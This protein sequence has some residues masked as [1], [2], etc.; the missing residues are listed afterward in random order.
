VALAK[1]VDLEPHAADLPS[2]RTAREVLIAVIREPA[3]VIG[4]TVII[5]VVLVAVLAPLL[6]PYSPTATDP[7]HIL[8][9]PGHGH[10]LGTDDAGRD[11]LSRVIF[12]TRPALLV[13]ALAVLVGGTLGI[14]LGVLAGYTRGIVESVIMRIC[15]VAFAFPLVLIGICAVVVLGPST[16]TVGLAVGIGVAPMFIRLARAEVLEET[17]LDHIHAA[18]GMGGTSWW[19]IRRHVIPNIMTTMIVQLASTMSVAVV[20]ASALDFLGLGAQVPAPS[21]GNMLQ[22]SRQ[23]LSQAP[24]FA[25]TPGVVLTVFVLA[26]NLFAAA[27]TNALD[28]RQRTRLLRTRGFVGRARY[29]GLTSAGQAEVLK[30]Q[31]TAMREGA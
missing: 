1:N 17:S 22:E 23:Y 26:V 21:W 29:R 10:L 18:R 13:A 5:A 11:V 28:P 6:A 20:I 4:G 25:I 19:I 2:P 16:S 9:G 14:G 15:D 24:L 31:E 27:L 12:G 7:T 30:G 3:G 8:A